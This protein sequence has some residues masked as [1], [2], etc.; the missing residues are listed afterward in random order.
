M[1]VRV[2]ALVHWLLVFVYRRQGWCSF[3]TI[4]A[5]IIMF[6]GPL[7]SLACALICMVVATVISPTEP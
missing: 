6:S 1:M 5:L 2:T 4:A 7:P 3:E